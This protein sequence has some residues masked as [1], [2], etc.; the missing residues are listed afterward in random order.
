MKIKNV[1]LLFE[2]IAVESD[3]VVC[4]ARHPQ[5]GQLLYFGSLLGFNDF[6]RSLTADSNPSTKD[7][8]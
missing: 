4:L 6:V 3:E 8:L 7:A 2:V 1:P 5:N